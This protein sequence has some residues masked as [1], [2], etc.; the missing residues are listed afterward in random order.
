MASAFEE[1]TGEPVSEREA[2][3]YAENLVRFFE[4]LGGW[5]GVGL[6]EQTD[7]DRFLAVRGD[8]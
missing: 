1:L 8:V 6:D 7:L 3:R 2:E 4:V 5:A